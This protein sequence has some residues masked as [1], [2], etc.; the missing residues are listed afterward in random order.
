M[1]LVLRLARSV[2]ETA[3]LLAEILNEMRSLHEPSAKEVWLDSTEVAR[4]LG[5]TERTI[6]TYKTN[7]VL[8]ARRIG[9]RDYFRESDIFRLP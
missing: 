7:G 9:R 5:V 2:M 4:R 3:R 6:Y 8:K 1:M